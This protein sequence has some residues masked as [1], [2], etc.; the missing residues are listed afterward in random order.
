[1]LQTASRREAEG[2]EIAQDH[3]PSSPKSGAGCGSAEF[4]LPSSAR[5][6]LPAGAVGSSDRRRDFAPSASLSIRLLTRMHSMQ[7]N[8]TKLSATGRQSKRRNYESRESLRIDSRKFAWMDTNPHSCEFV[9]A[10]VV[11]VPRTRRYIKCQQ[12][13][14]EH[15]IRFFWLSFRA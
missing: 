12:T 10:F 14:A 15:F 7:Y 5:D 4:P 3:W 6:S 11:R 2:T 1:V 13:L 8:A 9:S